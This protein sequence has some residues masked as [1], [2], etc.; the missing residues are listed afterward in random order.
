MNLA[1]IGFGQVGRE[2]ARQLDAHPQRFPF[3]IVGIHT[4][5]HGTLVDA[6]GISLKRALTM[7]ALGTRLATVEEFL[8]AC[9]PHAAVELTPLDPLT[10]EPAIRHLRA[11]L[12]RGIHAVTANK[13]PVAFAYQEL[14]QLA[15]ERGCL[16]RFESTVMDGAPVFNLVRRCLPGARVLGFTGVLNSTTTVVIEAMEEGRSFSEGVERARRMG[17][18]EANHSYDTDGWDAAAKTAALANVLLDARVTPMEIDRR[19]IGRLTPDRLRDLNAQG[20]TVRL[21]SR[22]SRSGKLRVRGEV[23]SRA[24]LLASAQGASGLLLLHTDLMGTVGAIEVAPTLA[25]TA[26]GVLADLTEIWAVSGLQ[27]L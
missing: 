25:Q 7:P 26:Y 1:L 9:R 13:G 22:G 18:T 6:A 11:A 17:I 24:D 19:G 4:L 2:L 27:P 14:A 5:R 8:E 3:R 10:G 16:F 23:L 12:E 15:R 21:V 20:K